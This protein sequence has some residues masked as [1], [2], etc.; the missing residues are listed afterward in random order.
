VIEAYKQKC[1]LYI[2]FLECFAAEIRDYV[3]NYEK[4]LEE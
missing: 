4:I 3:S 2:E 1:P